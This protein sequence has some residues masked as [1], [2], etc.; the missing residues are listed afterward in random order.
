VAAVAALGV[1]GARLVGDALV[2]VGIANEVAGA[3]GGGLAA[4][5]LVTI[6][7]AVTSCSRWA[8]GHGHQHGGTEEQGD[9]GKADARHGCDA[10]TQHITASLISIRK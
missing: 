8:A 9:R 5:A 7:V 2:G 10:I 6:A 4:I 3:V 1:A